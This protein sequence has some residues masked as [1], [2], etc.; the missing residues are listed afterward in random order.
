MTSYAPEL[1]TPIVLL[2][3][4]NEKAM[5]EE[6][7]N[8][9]EPNVLSATLEAFQVHSCTIKVKGSIFTVTQNTCC[10]LT[11]EQDF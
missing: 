6:S 10:N 2:S 9:Q 5:G 4:G 11:C 8:L 1:M 7:K 3:R